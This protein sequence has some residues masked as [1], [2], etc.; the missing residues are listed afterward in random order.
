MS[1]TPI[2]DSRRGRNRVSAACDACKARKVKCD[3]LLPCAYCKKRRREHQCRYTPPKQR[4]IPPSPSSYNATRSIIV[5]GS[6]TERTEAIVAAAVTGYRTSG[7]GVATGESVEESAVVPREARLLCDAQGKLIFIGDCAPLS[8]LQTVRHLI[9]TRI[10]PNGFATKAPR[11][12]IIEHMSPGASTTLESEKPTIDPSLVPPAVS[13]FMT[14][15]SGLVDVLDP[16]AMWEGMHRWCK[17]PSNCDDG[18][19]AVYYLVL[20][21]G[22]QVWHEDRAERYFKHARQLALSGLGGQ[23]GISTVQAFILVAVYM[24]STCQTNGAFLYLALAVRTAYAIG[25]HRT[26]VN[27]HFGKDTHRLRDQIWKSLRVV[28]LYLSCSLG[29]PPATSDVDCSVPYD[30]PAA[31]Q[32]ELDVLSASVQAFLILERVVVEIYSRK[33]ISIRLAEEISAQLRGWAVK[34]LA[35]LTRLTAETVSDDPESSRELIV[36]AAQVL[37]TYYY[38]VMLLTRPFLVYYLHEHLGNSQITVKDDAHSK[39]RASAGRAKFA[40]ATV[41]AAI[42]LVELVDGLIKRGMLTSRMPLVV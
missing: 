22:L 30:S 35:K 3:G 7:V 24:T 42:L 10:D 14:S 11:D 20:A 23:L 8:F 31:G 40:H 17:Q 6:D 25:L 5:P 34:W 37:S 1:A 15:T 33:Q 19:S 39:P 28:D 12:P 2:T 18:S 13:S 16:E 32:N 38:A 29:R 27:A 26:E 9:T 4:F 36:G 41:D 21:I